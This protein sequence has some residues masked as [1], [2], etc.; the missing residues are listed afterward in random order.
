MLTRDQ[1]EQAL[2]PNLR[3]AATQDFTDQ[4]NN[5]VNDPIMAEHI[6]ENFIT[7]TKVLMDGK[8]KTE[9]YLK[10]VV[11]VSF[12]H[13]GYSNKDAYYKTFPQRYTTLLAKNA[14]EKDISAYVAAYHKGKLVNMIM[15]Q[16]LIP[17][18][19]LN[20]ENYQKAINTQVKIMEDEDLPAVA[21]TQ[22]A[23]SILTHLA[24]P[25]EAVSTLKIE[26]TESAGL[27]ELRNMLS[28][29][30]QGQIAAIRE[31]VPT[32]MIAEQKLIDVTPVHIS[33]VD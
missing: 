13:M 29:L 22:A 19:I 24:K 18:W 16:S 12:K 33:D 2:P 32:K 6:R 5:A 21:R 31:G 14:S 17:F 10:A 15:E 30:A 9:D 25:K 8:F 27:S 28:S 7:Y 3:V 4:V 26:A 1:I 11:Y 23:N 20:Q